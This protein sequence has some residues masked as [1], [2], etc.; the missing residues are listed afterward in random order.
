[1]N[2]REQ[3]TVPFEYSRE[4]YERHYHGETYALP[5]RDYEDVFCRDWDK[6]PHKRRLKEVFAQVPMERV[7]DCL[8]VACH[9]GKT[10]FWLCEWYPHIR[11]WGF[12]F[13]QVAIDWCRRYNPFPDRCLFERAEIGSAHTVYGR[14]FDLVTCI[15]VTEHLPPSLVPAL[16]ADCAELTRPTGLL[17]LMQGVA[18]LPEHINVTGEA[19][20][21]ATFARRFQV[22]SRLPYR[23]YLLELNGSTQVD[24]PRVTETCCG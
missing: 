2:A 8:E 10:M 22:V 15:D 13:S 24:R 20:L 17:V 3:E 18:D 1:M 5:K 9:H 16:V 12:D 7:K 23:H 14:Q 4:W 21:L 19:E 6:R 11:Y